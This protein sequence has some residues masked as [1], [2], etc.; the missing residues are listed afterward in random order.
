[1]AKRV[2][3]I[4]S[5]LVKTR[6][7]APEVRARRETMAS[8]PGRAFGATVF[9]FLSFAP[10]SLGGSRVC[11]LSDGVSSDGVSSDGLFTCVKPADELTWANTGASLRICSHVHAPLPADLRVLR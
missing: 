3:S 9:D 7:L 6:S 5:W 1:M 2:P 11:L 4:L 10:T 8:G